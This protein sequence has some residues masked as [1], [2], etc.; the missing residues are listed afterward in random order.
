MSMEK[1]I[2][3]GIDNRLWEDNTNATHL[4]KG[5]YKKSFKRWGHTACVFGGF[6]FVFSG[7]LDSN[8]IGVSEAIHKICLED[9][10]NNMWSEVEYTVNGFELL[11]RDS[12]ASVLIDQKWVMLFGHSQLYSISE[13][14]Q[15]DFSSQIF[16]RIVPK[17]PLI[18][19]ESHACSVIHNRFIISYG[20]CTLAK[21]KSDSQDKSH[22]LTIIDYKDDLVL[23]LDDDLIANSKHFKPRKSHTI[24][25]VNNRLMV[26]GGSTVTSI[27]KVIPEDLLD[28]MFLIRTDFFKKVNKQAKIEEP[29]FT[30]LS[31]TLYVRFTFEKIEYTGPKV[32]M[33]CHNANL[34]GEELVVFTCGE[35]V[36]IDGTKPRVVCNTHVYAYSI[37][38]NCMFDILSLAEKIP[39]RISSTGSSSNNALFIYGGFNN[40]RKSL[41]SISVLTFLFNDKTLNQ[42][43]FSVDGKSAL[44]MDDYEL[45]IKKILYGMNRKNEI[46][47]H[48]YS[49]N[50]F[51]RNQVL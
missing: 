40:H 30:A 9:I 31:P 29:Y 6:L 3:E 34:V 15:Y 47:N 23:D 39:K 37:S 7:E 14:I 17:H 48:N 18:P 21:K 27:N 24:V 2:F 51:E 20:G 35:T 5:K 22:K 1:T 13:M 46:V 44:E 11:C 10:M 16:S 25:E 32:K 8:Q 19:R 36:I 43:T 38:K 50:L 4:S 12:F 41:S 28:D 49:K 45:S 42:K 33:H 26:F